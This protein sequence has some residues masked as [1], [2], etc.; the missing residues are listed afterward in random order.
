LIYG[1][2]TQSAIVHLQAF[3]LTKLR[4]GVQAG[5]WSAMLFVDNL[6][7]KAVLE[8]PQPQIDLALL[9]FQRYTVSQP[10]TAGIDLNYKFGGK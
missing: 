8:D 3:D 7:N 1:G 2:T 5:N 10:L 9:S 4:F 6:L